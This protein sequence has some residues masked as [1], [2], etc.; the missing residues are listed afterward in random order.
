M[1][2]R[3]TK[4]QVRESLVRYHLGE[5]DRADRLMDLLSEQHPNVS[6]ETIAYMTEEKALRNCVRAAL[7]KLLPSGSIN[8]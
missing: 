2:K 8:G 5:L 4:P 3:T 6:A 7:L 1:A